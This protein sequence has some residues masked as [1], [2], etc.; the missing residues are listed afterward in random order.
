MEEWSD[1]D[2]SGAAGLGDTP[3][4]QSRSASMALA[5]TVEQPRPGD[6]QPSADLSA[7]AR[8]VK[9][10]ADGLKELQ[11]ENGH[12]A[13]ELEADA[14]ITSEFILLEHFLGEIDDGVEAKLAVYIRERQAPHGGWPLFYGGDF[15]ISATVKAYFAL[16]LVGDDAE[17][18]HMARA[19]EAI[20]AHGGA[21]RCN[22]FSRFALALFGQVPWRA[23]PTM[24]VEIMLMPSWFPFRLDM[25]SYWSRT[26]IVPLLILSALKPEAKNPRGVDIAE[27]FVTPP[28]RE[29]RYMVN[30]TGAPLGQAF[31]LLDRILHL[32][33]HLIPKRLRAH[34]IDAAVAF[35]NKRANGEGGLGGIFPAM[36]NTLMAQAALGYA[37]DHPK[38][39][40]SMEAIRKLLV[41]GPDK[42][43]C[44]PCISPV[45]DTGLAMLALM[46]A[47]EVEDGESM[48]GA[49]KWL[50]DRQ[51]LEVEGDWAVRRP[52]LRP[53]GW[54]FQYRNDHYPDIDDTAVVVMALDRTRRSGNGVEMRTALARAVEWV[55]GMQSKDGGWGSFDADN[56]HYYLNHIPFADHGALLDS[57]TA[58]LTARCV[59]MLCQLGYGPGHPAVARGLDNL[60]RSQENDGSWYGRWGTN[61]I[62]GTWSALLAFSVAKEDH[63]SPHI[64]KAVAW[65][66]ACQREDGGWG[67]D[68]A[69][70]WPDRKG[71]AKASTPS[72]TAWA[73]LG[74]MAVGEVE[75]DAVAGGIEYLLSAPR[76]G[77]VWSERWY[78]AV[79]FPRVFY[80]RYHGYRTYFPLWALARYLN[81]MRGA[82]L[83]G[84]MGM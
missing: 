56:T 35:I 14:T 55:V 75:S 17:A 30:S 54:P 8:T 29:K 7:V 3:P 76:K 78:T 66:K 64:R 77:A 23:V 59:S 5:Q 49:V 11:A 9:S 44:Q 33:E 63:A 13:F 69:T 70:Y 34:A 15:N 2:N 84:V 57:P 36:A 58:D 16:K 62:Y 4:R 60:R 19:R 68:G 18:P 51:I 20:L 1:L 42:G 45:W 10:V 47:G 27:L 79:G 80:L 6:E 43:Y 83:P 26:V 39:R 25:V 31:L 40:A 61:Y 52:G 32:G 71:E 50:L 73:I 21:A 37:K 65:L 67:E 48:R 28:R 72:Q 12:W 81:L 41:L 22:V 38:R 82:T 74:L 46:E 53:G 24:P